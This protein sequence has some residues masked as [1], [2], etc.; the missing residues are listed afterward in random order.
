MRRVL[1]AACLTA[2]GALAGCANLGALDSG[3]ASAAPTREA[4]APETSAPEASTADGGTSGIFCPPDEPCAAPKQECCLASNGTTSCVGT[5]TC[6]NGT[7][8]YCDDP[9]QCA[10]GGT[11]WIC[12]AGAQ[13]FQGTS[14]NYQGDIVGNWHCDMS[15]ATRLC[16]SSSQCPVGTTCQALA[17]PDLDAGPDATWLRACR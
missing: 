1:A 15:T 13:G 14:C 7:D 16:H 17:V 4:S 12:I 11:C 10:D 6:S 3:D 8:I 2:V 5:G 9:G